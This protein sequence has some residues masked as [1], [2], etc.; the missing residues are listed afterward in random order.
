MVIFLVFILT[1]AILVVGRNLFLNNLDKLSQV[2]LFAQAQQAN[3]VAVAC[4][5]NAARRLQLNHSYLPDNDTVNL[6]GGQ[7]QLTINTDGSERI[8]VAQ[9]Q[10][11]TA[12]QS[13]VVRLNLSDDKLEL[14]D[15]QEY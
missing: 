2:D 9:G 1:L 6:A 8:I 11:G 15:W 3:Y 14:I 4:A 12:R 7:C 13:V 10:A 5:Q